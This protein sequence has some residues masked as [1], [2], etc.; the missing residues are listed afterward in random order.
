MHTSFCPFPIFFSCRALA[1]AAA[2]LLWAVQPAAAQEERRSPPER[3]PR[4]PPPAPADAP[5]PAPLVAPNGGA[6]SLSLRLP[7][8]AER[9][10][11]DAVDEDG[12]SRRALLEMGAVVLTGVG[13]LAFSEIG[14]SYAFIPLAALGW[15]GYVYWRARTDPGFLGRAGFTG[16]NLGAAFR[17][18][19][20]V[21]AGSVALMAVVGAARGTLQLRWRTLPL[22]A[23]YP[24]WGLV[25]QFLV[26]G[27]FA[28]HLASAPGPL[29]SPWMVTPV[30]A[31][32]FGAV[33]VP[34][35][36]LVAGTTA[37]GTA[38]TPLYLRHRNL[39]PLGLYHGA[40]GALYYD[41]VQGRNAW[42]AIGL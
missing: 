9:W 26:Q 22:V 13:H 1:A 21:A 38:F 36:A 29:G 23:L 19:S 25:Q 18:A 2:V 20:L 35:W 41:W 5:R 6:L 40:L 27:L 10:R 12:L 14:A 24:A 7:L 17:D 8:S 37:L 11:F 16:R 34:S 33:H 32:L 42:T 15:G 30:S 31:A 4:T 28:R 39:W 3:R